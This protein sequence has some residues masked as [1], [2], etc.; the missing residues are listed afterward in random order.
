LKNKKQIFEIEKKI[1]QEIEFTKKSIIELKA[2]TSPIA[3]DTAI[4]RISRMDAINNKTINEAA[5]QKA[6]RKLKSLEIALRNIFDKDFGLCSRCKNEIPIGRILL[7]P[8]IN[9][10]VHCAS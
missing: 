2:L 6:E 4:G 10:C 3:P 8:H 9:F 1:I 7:I 5:L